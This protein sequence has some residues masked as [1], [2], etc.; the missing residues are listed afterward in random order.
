MKY[1]LI[2]V[3]LNSETKLA[4]KHIFERSV[5]VHDDVSVDFYQIAKVLRF[6]FGEKSIVIF[7][8]S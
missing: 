8:I 3:A 5:S 7:Q 6:L 4:G 1:I 2:Q